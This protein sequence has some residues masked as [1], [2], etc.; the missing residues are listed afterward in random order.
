MKAKTSRFWFIAT[1]VL[2]TM[3]LTSNPTLTSKVGLQLAK[4]WQVVISRVKVPQPPAGTISP[5]SSS[6][7]M[8]LAG[9]T[10]PKSGCCQR[11]NASTP[12][13][14]PLRTSICG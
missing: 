8:K 4:L 14:N 3:Y 13:S 1:V 11:N 6:S 12:I 7:G 5:V 10:R 2:A 9:I